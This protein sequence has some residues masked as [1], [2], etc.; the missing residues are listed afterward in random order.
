VKKEVDIFDTRGAF[1]DKVTVLVSRPEENP[2]V[3]YHGKVYLFD[4][5]HQQY[6]EQQRQFRPERETR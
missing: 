5:R 1:V 2:V 3:R 4:P 6:R